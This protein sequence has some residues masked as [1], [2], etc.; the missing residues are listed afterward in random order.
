M[1]SIYSL[2]SGELIRNVSGIEALASEIMKDR[3]HTDCP[4]DF[5][6]RRWDTEARKWVEC[7]KADTAYR[8]RVTDDAYLADN[9]PDSINQA[10]RRLASEARLWTAFTRADLAPML[11]A[12]AEMRGLTVDA[13]A[14]LILEKDQQWIDSEVMRKRTKIGD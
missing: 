5:E 7:L 6:R 11:C 14:V 12:E 13:L 9:G 8:E 4:D 2:K 3:G 1:I 10:R